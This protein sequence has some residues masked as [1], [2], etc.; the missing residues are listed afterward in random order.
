[1]SKTKKRDSSGRRGLLPEILGTALL[2][3]GLLCYFAS[4]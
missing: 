3:L 1:M 2:F 4:R